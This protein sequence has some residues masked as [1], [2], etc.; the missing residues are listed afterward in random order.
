MRWTFPLDRL[1]G[2]DLGGLRDLI[3][4]A[5]MG[6]SGTTIA[7]DVINDDGSHRVLFEPFFP[8]RVPEAD[9]FA[10]IQ[11]LRPDQDDPV[12]EERAKRILSGRVHNAWVDRGRGRWIHRRRIVKDIRCNLMLGWL[13]RVAGGPPLVLTIRH[14]LQVAASWS[15]LG[16]G[17]EV[18]GPTSDFDVIS[19]QEAL[20]EDFPVV[21][22]ALEAIDADSF[23][24]RIVFQWAVFL[25]VPC[26]QLRATGAYALFYEN[27]LTE[28]DAEI[29]RLFRFLGKPYDADGMRR[30]LK[31]S[32][33]TNFLDRDFR[34]D[35][36]R[37]LDG[38]TQAFS[39]A[40]IRRANDILSVFGLD[41]VYDERGRPTGASPLGA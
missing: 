22:E 27:L 15:A 30:T 17:K 19:S 7:A 35:R 25:R 9:G 37:L 4:V 16:W 14:P 1:R 23:L 12:L 26:E 10:Y 11:Y 8:G 32:S 2:L 38:W 34:R 3:L 24:D 21:R 20:L 41:C 40:E 5:G 36:C 6:R 33:S 39:R 13:R 18:T 29:E 28:P 31:R